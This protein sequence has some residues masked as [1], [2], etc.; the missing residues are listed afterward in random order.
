LR[1][2]AQAM[3]M[4]IDKKRFALVLA[5]VVFV[6]GV[7]ALFY[8][9]FVRDTIAVPIY[10][11]LWVG[12]LILRSISQGVYLAFLVLLGIFIGINTVL[13]I[14]ARRTTGEYEQ[15]QF[16][17]TRYQHWK[18]LCT[19]L[20]TGRFSRE[21]FASEARKLL[22][23]ILAYQENIDI[24]EVEARVRDGTLQVPHPIK[25][26]IQHKEIE[27]PKQTVSI[28]Q[29]VMFRLRRL[30]YSAESLSN[31]QIERQVAEIISFIERQLEISHAGNQ[32][33]SQS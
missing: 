27:T 6:F 31:P 17:A 12:D 30:F 2:L 33:E 7:L 1:M 5:L 26:L 20:S 19:G 10:Y 32:P 14:R 25:H 8:W 21:M 15:N 3:G 24:S 9:N 13:G 16:Q 29:K 23:A 11:L 4:K 22:L 18:N 28:A